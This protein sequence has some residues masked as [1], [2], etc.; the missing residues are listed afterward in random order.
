MGRPTNSLAFKGANLRL[1]PTA[2]S[3]ARGA[4]EPTPMHNDGLAAISGRQD[5][6]VCLFAIAYLCKA[7]RVVAGEAGPGREQPFAADI[8]AT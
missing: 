1:N 8:E 6:V 5:N 3:R 7:E 4:T 2:C